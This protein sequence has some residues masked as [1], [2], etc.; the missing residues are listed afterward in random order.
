MF[1]SI[2]ACVIVGGNSTAGGFGGFKHT[3]L[4]VLFIT[5]LNN[6][7]NLLGVEWY[8]IMVVQGILILLAAMS[9]FILNRNI[10]TKPLEEKK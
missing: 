10:K 7:M 4:G 5:L 6:T 2:I 8:F 9:G 3:L 1:I